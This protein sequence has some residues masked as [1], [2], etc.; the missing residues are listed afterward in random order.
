ML[1]PVLH[2]SQ[3]GNLQSVM[4]PPSRVEY[5]Q[6]QLACVMIF[7]VFIQLLVAEQFAQLPLILLG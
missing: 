5:T 2:S 4:D 7:T 6:T 1:Y 3:Y